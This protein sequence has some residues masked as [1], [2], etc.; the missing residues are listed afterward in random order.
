M[1][2]TDKAELAALYGE[3]NDRA[4]L[5]VLP[6]LDQHCR[7]FIAHCPFVVL[8]TRGGDGLPDVSPRGDKPGFIR[9]LDDQT[10]ALPDRPGNRRIDTLKNILDDP[11]IA[12]LFI[13]PGFNDT[14][15]INGI[16]TIETD[17]ALRNQF[18][19]RDRAPLT[20]LKITVKQAFLHCA[21]AFMRSQLWNPETQ[22]PRS[23]L[24]PF[25]VMLVDHTGDKIALESDEDQI[26]RYER[27]LY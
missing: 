15:R 24:A 7:D 2:I 20:V 19:E 12:M 6:V 16:A 5:K 23:T 27:E 11:G 10:L 21:K 9:V 8:G 17:E 14:L 13:I 25:N 1:R 4:S 26:K 22:I 18:I 3:P